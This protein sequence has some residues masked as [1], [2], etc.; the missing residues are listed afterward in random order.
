MECLAGNAA[1]IYSTR[2]DAIDELLLNGTTGKIIQ[3]GR[4]IIAR[5]DYKSSALNMKRDLRTLLKDDCIHF[6][7]DNVRNQIENGEVVELQFD[8]FALRLYKTEKVIK[9][10]RMLYQVF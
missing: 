3:L 7:N 1:D 5:L 8:K 2:F 10:E 9:N 6:L 4:G